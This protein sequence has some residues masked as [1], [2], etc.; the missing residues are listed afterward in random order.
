VTCGAVLAT[1]GVSTAILPSPYEIGGKIGDKCPES[2]R[3]LRLDGAGY[4]RSI[5]RATLRTLSRS[6][7]SARRVY[8]GGY[9]IA[10]VYTGGNSEAG[11][12]GCRCGGVVVEWGN[13]QCEVLAPTLPWLPAPFPPTLHPHPPTLP[14]RHHA[15]AVHMDG[16]RGIQAAMGC[17][18]RSAAQLGVVG[19]LPCVTDRDASMGPQSQRSRVGGAG[20][21]HGV[22]HL[23]AVD[24]KGDVW[25]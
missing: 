13:A 11:V 12:G 6:L 2:L 9:T 25:Q 16:G 14:Y 7:T 3:N 19:E 5:V 21:R 17:R 8:T 18:T 24:S 20:A 1:R 10:K 15:H 4:A 22:A 23:A